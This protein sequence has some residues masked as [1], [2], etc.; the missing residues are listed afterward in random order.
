MG[1]AVWAR[2]VGVV[3]VVLAAAAVAGCSQGGTGSPS[4]APS[5]RASGLPSGGQTGAR[6]GLQDATLNLS[7]GANE[8]TVRSAALGTSLYQVAASGGTDPI[9][10]FTAPNLDVRTPSGHYD[11][12]QQLI[13]VLNQEVRWKLNLNGGATREQIDTRSGRLQSVALAA[14]ANQMDVFLGSAQGE[15]PVR[16]TGGANRIEL[17]IP[18]D[19][20]ASVRIVGAAN[21][22]TIN[23]QSRG[24]VAGGATFDVGS[25]T[26]GH[27]RFEL[28]AGL[29][30]LTVTQS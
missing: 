5:A 10:S 3:A 8:I 28:M 27:Y 26:S 13:V 30:T 29:N 6:N 20:A 2:M 23:G 7:A 14:G 17:R 25:N 19:S 24:R 16:I 9:V 15:V 11:S 22:V 4:A 18:T 21:A 1:R 12:P